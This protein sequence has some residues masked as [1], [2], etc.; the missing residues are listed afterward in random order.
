M[1][2]ARTTDLSVKRPIGFKYDLAEVPTFI[3]THELQ[4]MP[5]RAM[6][7]PGT[8]HIIVNKANLS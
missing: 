2:F 8:Q 4:T 1:L 5:I 6:K 7:S 3:R